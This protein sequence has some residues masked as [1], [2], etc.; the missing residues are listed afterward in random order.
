MTAR[1]GVATD[2]F[3]IVT[4]QSGKMTDR[5]PADD[6]HTHDRGGIEIEGAGQA[7]A[8]G[9]LLSV[10]KVCLTHLAQPICQSAAL[11]PVLMDY[12]QQHSWSSGRGP[13]LALVATFLRFVPLLHFLLLTARHQMRFGIG[14]L[15]N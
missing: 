7:V 8:S 13:P 14:L 15:R 11:V 2:D 10:W 3:G 1:S 12:Q 4:N 9:E 6:G 5:P